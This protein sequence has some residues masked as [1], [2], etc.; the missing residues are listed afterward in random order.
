MASVPTTRP[1]DASLAPAEQHRLE[2][3]GRYAVLGQPGDPL[4]NEL[5][6]LAARLCGTPMAMLAFVDERHCWIKAALGLDLGREPRER[7][8]CDGTVR[9]G[10]LTVIHDT[11]LHPPTAAHPLVTGDP[12]VRFFAG[13]PLLTEDGHAIGA[14]C[15]LDC[16]PRALGTEQAQ[17]LRSLSR[18][19]M[20]ELDLRRGR[21]ELHTVL[22]RSRTAHEDEERSRRD[23]LNALFERV[24][25]ATARVGE[26][27]FPSLVRNLALALEYRYAYV[28]ECVDPAKTRVKMLALWA[29]DHFGEP[30]EFALA[31]TP[32][33]EVFRCGELRQYTDRLTEIFPLA[34]PPAGVVSYLGLPI[35]DSAGE[36]NGH[37][38]LLD[39][40]PHAE[41]P[42]LRPALEIFA[43]RAGAEL[44]RLHAERLRRRA[45]L[46]LE[47]VQGLLHAEN[48]YLRSEVDKRGLDGI[49][50]DSPA[51]VRVMEKVAQVAPTDTTVLILGETGTGKELV[52][53]AIHARSAR[54]GRP[55]VCINCGA[56]T[57]S[58]VESELFGHERGSFTGATSRRIGR[59]E[60]ADGGTIFLDEIGDLP[61]DLQVRLLRVIQEGELVRVGG[62]QPTRVNVRIIAATH[63]DLHEAVRAGT[64]RADLYYRLNVF[65]IR[66]PALRDRV[67]DL[68]ALAEHF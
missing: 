48:E 1:S 13:E 64:F 20:R 46:E 16:V 43:S 29:G 52:A 53:R 14:L 11:T 36:V 42:W 9:A 21:D 3:L 33:C 4:F 55:M 19:A 59:F 25:G 49:V 6:V 35:R 68:P 31:G 63:R 47:R 39:E 50:G 32:C 24:T 60:L 30:Q 67:H 27:F 23:R 18:L 57:P 56:I 62:T 44:E 40:R 41:E 34:T 65:P 12:G 7:A 54:Q 2:A 17:S 8:L 61:L 28:T 51:I 15:V 38:V 5:T 22:E 26:E 10:L 45:M 58:L 66:M 37:L